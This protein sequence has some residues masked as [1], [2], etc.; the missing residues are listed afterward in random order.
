MKPTL[1]SLV[2]LVLSSRSFATVAITTST[3]P[4]GT[5]STPYSAVI[6]A[7]GGCTPYSWAITSGSL[8]A[9]V[10]KK[11]S[12]TTTALDLTG[13]PTTAA[14]Y[15]F[16]VL[17]RDCGGHESSAVY[18]TVIQASANHVVDLKWKPSSST[19]V[20]GY[21]VYRSPDRVTWKKANVSLIPWTT[22]SDSMVSNGSTYYYAATSVDTYGRESSKST[23][24][25]V[26]IP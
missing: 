5:V 2:V 14:S 11:P 26:S 8:P 10:S 25:R 20:S 1:L 24:I 15:S 4:G 6:Q 9:G 22:Y 17:V 19:D 16:T 7:T 23:A 13:T 18:K 21:N 3:L 12:N